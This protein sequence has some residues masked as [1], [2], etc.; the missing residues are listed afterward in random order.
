MLPKADAAEMLSILKALPAQ[1]SPEGHIST[2]NTSTCLAVYR[3][4]SI[5]T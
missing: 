3:D 2:F 1:P 5:V 4:Y